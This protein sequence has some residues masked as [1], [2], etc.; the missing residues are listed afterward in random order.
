MAF[1]ATA[2]GLAH[3]D[4]LIDRLRAHGIAYLG[5]GSAWAGRG[6]D[7]R[8]AQDAP[9]PPLLEDLLRS[10]DSRLRTAVVALLF[11]HPEYA[12]VAKALAIRGP[13][14]DRPSLL[15]AISVVAAAALQRMWAFS[16]DLYLPGW[17]AIDPG[18]LI[19]MLGVPPPEEDY[20]R[21]ALDALEARLRAED[22]FPTAYRT[23]WEDVARHVLD[24]LREESRHGAA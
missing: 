22:P 6:S 12:E 8:S 1:D 11:R 4:D 2:A 18:P 9:V 13:H 23:A 15:L 24:D 3:R 5:G 16:L 20:G 21:A 17:V 7:Y 19:A 10:D 14:T